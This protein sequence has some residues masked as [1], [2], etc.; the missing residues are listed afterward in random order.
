MDVIQRA[1]EVLG[2]TR[3]RARKMSG[4]AVSAGQ[5]PFRESLSGVLSNFAHFSGVV[6]QMLSKSSKIKRAGRGV[7]RA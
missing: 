4:R 5:A 2:E 3:N 7:Y 1:P 6:R